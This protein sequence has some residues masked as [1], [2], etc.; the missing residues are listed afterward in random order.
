MK[1]PEVRRSIIGADT[2]HE[3]DQNHNQLG[4]ICLELRRDCNIILSKRK[5]EEFRN[6]VKI[7][8]NNL[9]KEIK[10]FEEQLS[11]TSIKKG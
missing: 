5:E 11:P 3:L 6:I 8:F 9:L 10:L 7:A 4:L 1:H 2:I